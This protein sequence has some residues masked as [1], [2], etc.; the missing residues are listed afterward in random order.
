M[1]K[2]QSNKVAKIRKVLAAL[3][4]LIIFLLPILF[5][6]IWLKGLVMANE[7]RPAYSQK[8]LT[9]FRDSRYPVE[10]G[11]LKPFDEPV[12]TITFDDGWE[13][14]Y[15]DG[16]PVLEKYGIKSTQY[17]LGDHF[18]DPLYMSEAQAHDIQ[19]DGHEIA[20][21]T[22]THPDLTT[23]DD[24]KLDWELGESDRLLTAKFGPMQDF[25]TPFG[26]SNQNVVAHAKP[27]YRSIR[28]TA[29][30]PAVLDN[31][32]INVRETFNQYNINAY[33]VRSTTTTE[34]LQKLIDYAKARKGWLVL[35]YHQVDDKN[36][37]W[38]VK[39]ETL[40]AQLKQIR[41][42]GVRTAPMGQVL[43]TLHVK[44]GQ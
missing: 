22:M 39:H 4:A 38:S 2:K 21:H 41:D 16:L 25:A 6:G 26:A 5:G 40:D 28:N 18:D 44:G 36:S 10:T 24:S 43:D 31:D 13:S 33:T 12:I 3:P 1:S 9:S 37:F 15:H 32:D 7:G 14:A 20:P 29:A 19:T 8:Q 11:E 23:L 42:S 34:D 27:F 30:D 35:T 17:I